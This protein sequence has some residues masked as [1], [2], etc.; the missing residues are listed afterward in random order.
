MSNPC[1][2]LQFFSPACLDGILHIDDDSKSIL[3]SRNKGHSLQ[4]THTGRQF[5]LVLEYSISSS[6]HICF[7][8]RSIFRRSSVFLLGVSR[9][10]SQ[11]SCQRHIGA[12]TI[13]HEF[14]NS[15]NRS[16]D[17]AAA[18][19]VEVTDQA[20]IN[21]TAHKFERQKSPLP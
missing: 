5:C 2:L 4:D 11:I 20:C 15:S 16:R 21:Q 10:I 19:T 6:E 14:D 18:S 1:L 12:G 17:N 9:G 8:S 7:L 13:L 3:R